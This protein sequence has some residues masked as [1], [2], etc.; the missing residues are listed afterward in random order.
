MCPYCQVHL[1]GSVLEPRALRLLYRLSELYTSN[2]TCSVTCRIHNL[3]WKKAILYIE[4]PFG[5]I[6]IK[7]LIHVI[8]CNVH[9]WKIFFV[10]WLEGSVRFIR[11]AFTYCIFNALCVHYWHLQLTSHRVY[12]FPWSSVETWGQISWF[13]FWCVASSVAP[14]SD[15]SKKIQFPS[16]WFF[17][18]SGGAVDQI[19]F[20]FTKCAFQCTIPLTG[21]KD[22]ILLLLHFC[23][24]S[25]LNWVVSGY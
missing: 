2:V 15:E 25:A 18:F 24:G 10:S 19:D 5:L 22:A 11:L 20:W 12:S 13:T 21:F 3:F 6:I 1:H 8:K 7:T 17:V 14:Q 16:C 23:Q 4:S 9:E